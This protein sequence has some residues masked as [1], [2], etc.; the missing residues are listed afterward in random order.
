VIRPGPTVLVNEPVEF[1]AVVTNEGTYPLEDVMV[2]LELC[3]GMVPRDGQPTEFTIAS[4]PVG[5]TETRCV[6]LSSIVL[7]PCRLA[8]HAVDATGIAASGCYCDLVVEGLPALQ[9]Q[10]WDLDAAG[11]PQGVFRVGEEVVYRLLVEEDAGSAG[12]GALVVAWSLPP[13]LEYVSGSG[14][15]GVTVTGSGA[16]ATSS[17]F[18]LLPRE[19]KAF[20]IRCRVRDVPST[21]L[22]QALARV[23]TADGNQELALETESTTLRR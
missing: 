16:N 5:A 17:A 21:N 9:L 18:T 12:T 19:A 8:A 22:V 4:L 14:P 13:Q 6:T 23:L 11:S 3:C 10:M 2:R 15:E 20:E 7:G 1:C